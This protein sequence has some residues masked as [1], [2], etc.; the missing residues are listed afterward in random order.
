MSSFTI[1]NLYPLINF[2]LQY[3]HIIEI[4]QLIVEA[5]LKLHNEK[6]HTA[7]NI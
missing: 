1:Y 3:G 5:I 7:K 4:N 6:D 2:L